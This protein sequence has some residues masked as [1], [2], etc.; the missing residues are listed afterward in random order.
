MAIYDGEDITLNKR[1]LQILKRQLELMISFLRDNIDNKM[2][3]QTNCSYE[4]KYLD[5]LKYVRQIIVR[6]Y[7]LRYGINES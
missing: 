5:G 4:I 6:E 2:V 7:D 3:N 1:E